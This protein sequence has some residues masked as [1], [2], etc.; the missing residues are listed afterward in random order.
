MAL[1]EKAHLRASLIL[2]SSLDLH[3]LRTNTDRQA[4]RPT[5]FSLLRGDDSSSFL[6][7]FVYRQRR[8]E[9]G[10]VGHQTR[11]GT[12]NR[13]G[14]R[15]IGMD[16]IWDGKHAGCWRT[17]ERF[18]RW[19]LVIRG[20]ERHGWQRQRQRIRKCKPSDSSVLL[21]SVPKFSIQIVAFSLQL[22]FIAPALVA[23]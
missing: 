2:R 5:Q 8:G 23:A 12:V 15:R 21:A 9:Q 18:R 4:Y 22:H 6:P 7:F 16:G 3:H 14:R 17:K 1:A 10:E 20:E 13:R 11:M 19:A